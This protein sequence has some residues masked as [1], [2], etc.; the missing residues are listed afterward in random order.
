MSAQVNRLEVEE[1]RDSIVV[2]FG[3]TLSLREDNIPHIATELF[4]VADRLGRRTLSFDL[5]KV[6]FL[7]SNA[8]GELIKLHKRVRTGGGRLT[9]CNAS[10]AVYEVFE[11][12]R[13][14]EVMDIIP[15][16]SRWS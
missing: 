11:I 7:T 4:Q 6:D 1:A 2:R 13:L 12:T 3:E 14:H 8:L 16:S 10:H 15:P 9:L 5:G